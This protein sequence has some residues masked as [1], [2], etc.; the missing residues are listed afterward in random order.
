[1][2]DEST[3]LMLACVLKKKKFDVTSELAEILIKAQKAPSTSLCPF[4]T[5]S[6]HTHTPDDQIKLL[7]QPEYII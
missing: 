5:I 2:D 1:M 7:A 4:T 6:T 3:R